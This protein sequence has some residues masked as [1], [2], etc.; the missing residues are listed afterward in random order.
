MGL[1]CCYYEWYTARV[2]KQ[3]ESILGR[4]LQVVGD[5]RLEVR[6]VGQQLITQ[7]HCSVAGGLEGATVQELMG[8]SS[9]GRYRP[10]EGAGGR[11]LTW[12][13]CTQPAVTARI[14]VIE[15]TS[16]M[17]SYIPS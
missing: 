5:K 15:Q 8:E 3:G 6:A 9:G 4:A 16:P 2:K 13:R 11:G 14:L 10:G 12:R 17:T 1:G 7:C